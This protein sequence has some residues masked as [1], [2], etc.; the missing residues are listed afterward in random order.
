MNRALVIGANGQD[1]GFLVGHLL[2]KNY[3][4][5]GIGRQ[6]CSRYVFDSPN[7]S[8]CQAD[9]NETETLS[10]PLASFQPDLIFHVAAVH[11]SAGGEYEPLFGSVLNV[12]VG[13]VHTVLEH[14]R[15]NGG[16]RF[17]YASS[18]KVF[19]NPIPSLINESTPKQNHC[20]YSIS[21]NT[22]HHLIDYY[23]GTYGLP[24]SVVYLFNHESEYRPGNFFIPKI[25][26]CLA[27][28]VDN[29][30][31][32]TE[33]DTLNFHCDWGSAEEYMD[34]MVEIVEKSPTEDFVLATGACTYARDLIARLFN[35]YGLKYE[36]N[37]VERFNSDNLSDRP[38]KVELDKLEKY[39]SRSPQMGVF[40]ICKRILARNYGL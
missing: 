21:K 4:V 13:S 19:G 7:Y 27:S 8:Y 12:N 9:L 38:Y 18:G 22:A 24:A 6:A 29:P 16:C 17:I 37:L 10:E 26:N 40:D 14:M 33:I 30:E 35:D 34:I 5:M 3:A 1:G 36:R 32:I 11:T 20:L 31:H 23:R 39:L 15:S 28:A 25:L 2:R